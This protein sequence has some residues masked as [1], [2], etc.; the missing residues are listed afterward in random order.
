MPAREPVGTLWALPCHSII[1]MVSWL[2]IIILSLIILVLAK[3][4]SSDLALMLLC[5]MYIFDRRPSKD[6]VALGLQ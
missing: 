1:H 2:N 3:T 5:T 6:W 4:T